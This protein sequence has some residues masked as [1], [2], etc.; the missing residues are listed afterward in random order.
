[1]FHFVTVAF[2]EEL[3]YPFVRDCKPNTISDIQDGALYKELQKPGKFLSYPEHTG[4]MLNTDGV[5]VF[6]SV[7]H[8]IWP[9]YLSIV[10]L[11]PHLRMR[12]DFIMLA[13]VWFGPTKPDMEVILK[14]V[15][16]EVDR[17]NTLGLDVE[18]PN[19][20][21]TIGVKLLLSMFDLPAKS[22][23]VNMKQFNGRYGCLYC[24]HPGETL[25]RGCL[26]YKPDIRCSLRTHDTLKINAER[27]LESGEAE[28]GIKGP[29]VLSPYL[30]VVDDIP[31]DYMHTVL[32]G[33][34]KQ[35]MGMWFNSKH[36]KKFLLHGN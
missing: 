7:K 29:S 14:P 25:F 21:K 20:G 12:K 26:I 32:E 6:G 19:G 1:M 34:T 36:H 23:A 5:A 3:Q 16:E 33:V 4:L 35:I 17:I 15:L 2:W 30:N 11:P 22:M 10:S 28:K 13:G 18:T 27:A 8:S 24:E 9:I 31:V